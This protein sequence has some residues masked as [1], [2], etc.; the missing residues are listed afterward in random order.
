M[1]LKLDDWIKIYNQVFSMKSGYKRIYDLDKMVRVLW[2]IG[3]LIGVLLIAS[4]I[5]FQ[6]NMFILSV[7]Y[8]IFAMGCLITFWI[9]IKRKSKQK[10]NDVNYLAKKANEQFINDVSLTFKYDFRKEKVLNAII[11]YLDFQW[12]KEESKKTFFSN[13]SLAIKLCA[14]SLPILISYA[15]ANVDVEII[16]LLILATICSL[17]FVLVL[18]SVYE[19][20][21]NNSKAN[22]IKWILEILHEQKIINLHK[23]L[24]IDKVAEILEGRNFTEL[25]P[26]ILNDAEYEEVISENL[27][28]YVSALYSIKHD[29]Y[30]DTIQAVINKYNKEFAKR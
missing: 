6:N 26:E 15:I 23:S 9:R 18:Q 27:E 3:M 12:R 2:I 22:K 4:S 28:H 24:A 11:E 16:G 25:T 13:F 8:I 30:P 1:A 21:N 29:V 10:Y 5:F 7:I 19:E 14:F 20:I 17:F